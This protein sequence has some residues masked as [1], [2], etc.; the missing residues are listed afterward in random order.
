MISE[1]CEEKS[2][3]SSQDKDAALHYCREVRNGLVFGYFDAVALHPF[4]VVD[5]EITICESRLIRRSTAHYCSVLFHLQ[6]LPAVR[7]GTSLVL[8]RHWRL[9]P[10]RQRRVHHL[11]RDQWKRRYCTNEVNSEREYILTLTRMRIL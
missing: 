1:M 11:R 7:R 8:E 5:S 2:S 10:T 6:M 3:K 9:L 4:C